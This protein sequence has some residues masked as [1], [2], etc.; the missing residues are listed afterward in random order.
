VRK[1]ID[2]FLADLEVLA[3]V[4]SSGVSD[5]AR[6][7]LHLWLEWASIALAAKALIR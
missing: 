6:T 2:T 4:L 3:Y 5:R 1:R 7:R